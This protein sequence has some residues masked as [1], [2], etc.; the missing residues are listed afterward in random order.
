MCSYEV[1]KSKMQ[2]IS[3]CW[4]QCGILT[5]LLAVINPTLQQGLCDPFTLQQ[6]V[7]FADQTKTDWPLQNSPLLR[8]WALPPHRPHSSLPARGSSY[9]NYCCWQYVTLVRLL[10]FSNDPRPFCMTLLRQIWNQRGGGG[11][12]EIHFSNHQP[13]LQEHFSKELC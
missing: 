6:L 9:H 10:I 7:Y 13:S 4:G 5:T 11:G 2:F 12:R 3:H 8:L 1:S